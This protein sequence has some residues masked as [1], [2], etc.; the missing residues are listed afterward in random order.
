MRIDEV[1]DGSKPEYARILAVELIA[2]GQHA[3][4]IAAGAR[5][6]M[7]TLG[8]QA[9]AIAHE[10][11]ALA[12]CSDEDIAARVPQVRSSLV[13]LADALDGIGASA[14]G[15]SDHGGSNQGAHVEPLLVEGRDS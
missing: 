5:T 4:R 10:L 11:R 12:S 8:V 13:A 1:V 6:L 9:P 3:E 7:S 15:E 14:R 2:M